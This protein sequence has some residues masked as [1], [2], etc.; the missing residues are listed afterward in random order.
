MVNAG[1]HASGWATTDGRSTPRTGRLSPTSSSPSPSPAAGPGSSP[2]ARG[3]RPLGHRHGGAV[4]GDARYPTGERRRARA[5]VS[6]RVAPRELPRA[7]A[8]RLVAGA[9]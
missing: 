3:A 1:R 8:P 7:H 9:K 5:T 6:G 2:V 4:A